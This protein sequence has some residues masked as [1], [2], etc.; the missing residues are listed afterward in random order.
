MESKATLF[1]H[2]IHQMMIVLPLGVLAMALIFDLLAAVAGQAALGLAAH[3]MIAA[4]VIAGLAAA[5]PGTIDWAAIPAG[6]R[7]RRIG[8]AHGLGNVAVLAL[9]AIAWWLRRPSPAE[10]AGLPLALEVVAGLGALVTGWLGGELVDRLGVGVHPGANL[11]APS[12]LSGQ[13]ASSAM[14]RNAGD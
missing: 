10:A 6:T 4:G 1:G 3:A 8:L 2:P 12:S 13:P 7:A 9:F 11:D 5:I 14:A